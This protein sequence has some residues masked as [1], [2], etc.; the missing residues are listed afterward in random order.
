MTAQIPVRGHTI[1]FASSKGGVGKTTSCSC[2]AVRAARDHPKIAMVDTD[3]SHGLEDWSKRRAGGNPQQ[4]P[5]L[6]TIKDVRNLGDGCWQLKQ[7]GWGFILVDSPPAPA[8]GFEHAIKAADFVVIPIKASP[9]D[10]T[11]ISATV[12]ACELH[13]K[14]FAFLL[15]MHVAAWRVCKDARSALQNQFGHVLQHVLSHNQAYVA[16]MTGGK[17][18]PEYSDK[19]SP[20][21]TEKLAAEAAAEVD[22]IWAE[23]QAKMAVTAR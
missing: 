7:Q 22:A 8:V 21:T 14:P 19:R 1:V 16:A 4:N 12:N 11:A 13:G 18:G 15:T 17:T 3:S 6:F 9:L 2:L 23:I 5:R 20:K 10:I